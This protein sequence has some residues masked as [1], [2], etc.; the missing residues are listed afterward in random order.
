MPLLNSALVLLNFSVDKMNT[1]VNAIIGFRV[2]LH[3]PGE[4]PRPSKSFFNLPLEQQT[5]VS[6]K[7]NMIGTSDDLKGYPPN[8]KQCYMN[9][10]RKLKFFQVYTQRH[11]ELE[12]LSIHMEMDC[13]CVYFA[14]PSKNKLCIVQYSQYL[15]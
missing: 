12:C 1:N 3:T 11:C 5:V 6:I 7:P 14:Y 4:I 8:R 2:V 13:G 15:H 10:E 9:S